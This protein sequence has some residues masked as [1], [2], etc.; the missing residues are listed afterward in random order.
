MLERRCQR[1]GAT[2]LQDYLEFLKREAHG[3]SHRLVIHRDATRDQV[4]RGLER[5]LLHDCDPHGL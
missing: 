4:L 3:L 5:T 2:G 1:N